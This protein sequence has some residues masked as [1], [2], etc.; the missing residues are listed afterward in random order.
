MCVEGMPGNK[1]ACSTASMGHGI[2]RCQT[3]SLWPLNPGVYYIKEPD[4][5]NSACG[6]NQMANRNDLRENVR[7]PED[8]V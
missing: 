5:M 4:L 2:L 8:L 3:D 6:K 1:A 7:K